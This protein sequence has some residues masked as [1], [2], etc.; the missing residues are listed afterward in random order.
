M[1]FFNFNRRNPN[2]ITNLQLGFGL[3]PAFVDSNLARANDAKYMTA[4]HT[5]AHDV[6]EII[7]PLIL[8]AFINCD[9]YRFV[10]I[11]F[12]G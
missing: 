11:R 12:Y 6:Q 3:G 7:Q 4:W 9:D 8:M 5:L 10:W 2:H 1:I